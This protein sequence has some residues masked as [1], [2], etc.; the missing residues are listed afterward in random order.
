MV[1]LD[2]FRQV[3]HSEILLNAMLKIAQCQEVSVE[4]PLWV[5]AYLLFHLVGLPECKHALANDTPQLVQISVVA[6]DL[7]GE[8]EH[9][10]K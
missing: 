5:G 8:Y 4:L 9:G 1:V 2:G 10:N 3:G 7:G 6:D